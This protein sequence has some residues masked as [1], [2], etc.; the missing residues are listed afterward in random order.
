MLTKYKMQPA[1]KERLPDSQAGFRKSRGC[2]D[3]VLILKLLI[4][5]IIKAGQEAVIVFI[6]YNVAF[7]CVSLCFFDE[8]LAEANI[9]VKVQRIIKAI[10]N[11]ATGSVR[12]H[13]QSS[14]HVC[15]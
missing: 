3:N 8:S 13:Q 15:L 2:R 10:Y 5:E 7:D 1:L 4:D 9:P 11:A 14:H 12:L 6:D